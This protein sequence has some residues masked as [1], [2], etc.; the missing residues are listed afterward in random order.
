MVYFYPT[1]LKK[2]MDVEYK[3]IGK[4]FEK[5]MK[6]LHENPNGK[7]TCKEKP[8]TSLSAIFNILGP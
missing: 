5:E 6:Q 2:H 3:W 7:A 4:T 8:W 1:V